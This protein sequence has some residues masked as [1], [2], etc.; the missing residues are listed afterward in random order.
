MRYLVIFM[1]VFLACS[2][3]DER[4]TQIIIPEDSL[5]ANVK[6]SIP[7]VLTIDKITNKVEVIVDRHDLS[8]TINWS[9]HKTREVDI[10]FWTFSGDMTNN[11]DETITQIVYKD[12]HATVNGK[13]LQTDRK[14]L[15]EKILPGQTVRYWFQTVTLFM[16]AGSS[17]IYAVEL[18]G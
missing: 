5:I 16:E 7:E 14:V 15:P 3:S 2:N 17:L 9:V 1:L 18:E 6:V 4:P 11:T 8:Y 13:K 10:W 12:I